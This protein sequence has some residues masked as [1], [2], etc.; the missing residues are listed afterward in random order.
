MVLKF[1]SLSGA[2]KAYL[3]PSIHHVINTDM[4][5]LYSERTVQFFAIH[6]HTYNNISRELHSK[7]HSELIE[8][9][10]E[11]SAPCQQLHRQWP[12]HTNKQQPFHHKL[13]E[14]TI[15]WYVKIHHVHM[16]VTYAVL[17]SFLVKKCICS[18]HRPNQVH[19]S[20]T[21]LTYKALAHTIQTRKMCLLVL[22]LLNL[23]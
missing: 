19:K 14:R 2:F 13:S 1:R 4:T 21:L 9:G 17:I 10:E 12:H 7:M 15:K 22:Q 18:F 6:K 8:W 23:L 20:P 5:R 3:Y 11:V 16:Q